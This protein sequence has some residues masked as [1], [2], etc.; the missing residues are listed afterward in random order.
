L[1][2]TG[3]TTSKHATGLKFNEKLED[4]EEASEEVDNKTVNSP[5]EAHI[6]VAAAEQDAASK[7]AVTNN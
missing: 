1:Q 2:I 7:G 5:R 6:E 4:S 3:Q